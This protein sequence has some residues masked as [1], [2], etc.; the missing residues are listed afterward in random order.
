MKVC[1]VPSAFV[2]AVICVWVLQI[3]RA[4]GDRELIA[5]AEYDDESEQ[6]DNRPLASQN[7]E[8]KSQQAG[9]Y[10]QNDTS[11]FEDRSDA[12][13]LMARPKEDPLQKLLPYITFDCFGRLEGYYADLQFGCEVFHYCKKEGKRFSFICPPN[14]TF[15]Q[16]LMI[17]DYDKT[18][19]ETCLEAP[20]YFHLNQQLYG[21]KK[22]YKFPELV[23]SESQTVEKVMILETTTPLSAERRSD[24]T[25]ETTEKPTLSPVTEQPKKLLTPT[26][27]RAKIRTKLTRPSTAAPSLASSSDDKQNPLKKPHRKRKPRPSTSPR[28]ARFE[29]IPDEPKPSPRNKVRPQRPL[30]TPELQTVLQVQPA[31]PEHISHAAATKPATEF[32]RQKVPK[33]NR[34]KNKHP[35]KPV[36]GEVSEYDRMLSAEQPSGAIPSQTV[37]GFANLP[38][39]PVPQSDQGA[40]LLLQHQTLPNQQAALRHQHTPLRQQ[41]H[42]TQYQAQH[43]MNSPPQQY[44]APPTP[45]FQQAPPAS[46]ASPK[47]GARF[48]AEQTQFSVQKPT[49]YSSF[50]PG[51]QNTAPESVEGQFYRNPEELPHYSTDFGFTS[52]A[53]QSKGASQFP[54]YAQ[55]TALRSPRPTAAPQSQFEYVYPEMQQAGGYSTAPYKSSFTQPQFGQPQ[56]YK[57]PFEQTQPQF[58]QGTPPM[59]Q[60]HQSYTPV[61]PYISGYGGLFGTASGSISDGFFTSPTPASGTF[62]STPLFSE[63]HI[64]HIHSRRRRSLE[65][66]TEMEDITKYESGIPHSRQRRQSMFSMIPNIFSRKSQRPSHPFASAS[67]MNPTFSEVPGF[68]GGRFTQ[69]LTSES[70][71]P[72]FSN[73]F[74]R[75]F[76]GPSQPPFGGSGGNH[77]RVPPMSMGSTGLFSHGRGPPTINIG[78]PSTFTAVSL[79]QVPSTSELAMNNNAFFNQATL[80]KQ[81]PTKISLS[82]PPQ[83]ILGTGSGEEI[84]PAPGTMSQTDLK[85]ST[86]ALTA[87][88]LP[89]GIPPQALQQSAEVVEED[90]KTA[91]SYIPMSGGKITVTLDSIEEG[92]TA[93]S[94]TPLS[95]PPKHLRP[96]DPKEV[97]T[98]MKK[99]LRPNIDSAVGD[100][101]LPN[102]YITQ[103][104]P[105]GLKKEPSVSN[106]VND[107]NIIPYP[108]HMVRSQEKFPKFSTLLPKTHINS[109]S[110]PQFLV[111]QTQFSPQLDYPLRD[112]STRGNYYQNSKNTMKPVD[113][114]S[115]YGSLSDSLNPTQRPIPAVRQLPPMPA[116]LD[117][118]RNNKNEDKSQKRR[119]KTRKRRPKPSTSTPLPPSMIEVVTHSDSGLNVH[120]KPNTGEPTTLPTIST[121]SSDKRIWYGTTPQP[122]RYETQFP[123][124]FNYITRAPIGHVSPTTTRAPT[125]LFAP[126]TGSTGKRVYHNLVVT[127]SFEHRLPQRLDVT[128]APLYKKNM[129]PPRV[130]ATNVPHDMTAY[131]KYTTTPIPPSPPIMRTVDLSTT[132]IEPPLAATTTNTHSNSVTSSTSTSGSSANLLSSTF[133]VTTFVPISTNSTTTEKP[134]VVYHVTTTPS[135]TTVTTATRITTTEAPVTTTTA[136]VTSKGTTTIT[137]RPTEPSTTP[138][139]MFDFFTFPTTGLQSEFSVPKASPAPVF[140]PQ[141]DIS[142]NHDRQDEIIVIDMEKDHENLTASASTASISTFKP[143]LKVFS[144]RAGGTSWYKFK[145]MITSTTPRPPLK[146]L[147]AVPIH[148]GYEKG[149]PFEFFTDLSLLSKTT[150]RP[151]VGVTDF[152]QPVYKPQSSTEHD[153]NGIRRKKSK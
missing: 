145:A 34:K 20:R 46:A 13:P 25:M 14:S 58:A 101:T 81:S 123:I 21:I 26:S 18:A 22:N 85:P 133:P 143:V 70:Q 32:H 151:K 130:M 107:K 109:F 45:H 99:S 118:N 125:T 2:L 88:K 7:T 33:K 66:D 53:A 30:M 35:P 37:Q 3:E 51:R 6:D 59:F 78:G 121:T 64:H 79:S 23:T 48:P 116:H 137:S 16:R 68:Y 69:Q 44:E 8:S 136:K 119:I 55:D 80:H 153:Q 152:P 84:L 62:S 27:K 83:G 56:T 19:K 129:F 39:A 127:G 9:Q 49:A 146:M 40:Q 91:I 98:Q 115:N 87:P 86:T 11:S 29:P 100:L 96:T 75:F 92:G 60:E 15:N 52:T 47:S 144:N 12:D 110:I 134:V 117:P 111:P 38:Q 28:P 104:T 89:T 106:A 1:A 120:L 54:N 135:A 139:E 95:F 17:C 65:D 142:L 131:A 73:T 10:K 138:D 122:P 140:L 141:S 124:K 71:F 57:T 97:L 43:V 42:I 108:A 126:T 150:G 90:D 67:A 61:A 113:S 94:P 31:P 93:K 103:V 149:F 74:T 147:N 82:K 105:P 50:D 24:A 148:D 112:S 4:T 63:Q 128:N 132:T 5:S 72:N 102:D 77:L 76:A 114:I 41:P 36:K